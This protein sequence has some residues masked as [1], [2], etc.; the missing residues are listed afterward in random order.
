MKKFIIISLSI[1]LASTISF[2]AVGKEHFYGEWTSG[3]ELTFVYNISANSFKSEIVDYTS[4][5]IPFKNNQP[6]LKWEYAKNP[7]KTLN[8][9]FPDGY[10]IKTKRGDGSPTYFYL[11]KHY[12]NNN[13]IMWQAEEFF[14]EG[15]YDLL[16]KSIPF[17]QA[18][19]YGEWYLT[20][21]TSV[22]NTFV[23]TISADNIKSSTFENGEP[24][25]FYFHFRR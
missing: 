11:W 22:D 12:K 18:D 7:N 23:M 16:K 1:L 6:L 17:K 5:G 24:V 8:A 25:K 20:D 10:L 14:L 15:K 21:G 2:A 19:F 4:L 9:N 13:I 3:D